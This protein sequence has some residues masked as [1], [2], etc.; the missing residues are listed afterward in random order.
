MQWDMVAALTR[1]DKH[2]IVATRVKME[3]AISEETD[4]Q[5]RK[6]QKVER[7]GLAPVQRGDLEYEFQVVGMLDGAH[8]ITVTKSRAE[9]LAS[10]VFRANHQSDFARAYAEWLNGGMILAPQRDVDRVRDR[11]R[12]ITDPARRAEISRSYKATFGSPDQ[13][14]AERV[15]EVTR[16]LDEQRVPGAVPPPATGA[17]QIATPA[18]AHDDEDEERGRYGDVTYQDSPEAAHAD[19]AAR[20]DD[21]PLPE[22]PYVPVIVATEHDDETIKAL[23]CSILWDACMHDV[24][25]L[26]AA[27]RRRACKNYEI[28]PKSDIYTK[29]LAEAFYNDEAYIPQ[30]DPPPT[31]GD[32]MALLEAAAVPA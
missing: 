24:V 28:D 16:W 12:S 2:V 9:P 26:D 25:A 4:N 32:L 13:L 11:V 5:G 19:P 30:A 22:S 1:V 6:K 31:L 10:K 8:E 15:D 14:L 17:A 27:G 3:Y 29:Q 7:V 18:E 23:A 20:S 21:D